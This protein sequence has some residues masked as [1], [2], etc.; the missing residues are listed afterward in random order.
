MELLT[1]NKIVSLE[2]DIPAAI[3]TDTFASIW[4][5]VKA[6]NES[7]SKKT[8]STSQTST[9][10][11]KSPFNS[12]LI[13]LTDPLATSPPSPPPSSLGIVKVK[14]GQPRKTDPKLMKA[15]A[16]HAKHQ[17]KISEKIAVL[18]WYTTHGSNQSSTA[19][20]FQSIYPHLNIKQP[21]VSSWVKAEARL[22]KQSLDH[23][24]AMKHDRDLQY[25][26]VEKL[27]TKWVGEAILANVLID[28]DVI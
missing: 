11:K 13:S 10:L 26:G 25:P 16:L 22:R 17:A 8:T 18:D 15:R 3:S 12:S 20:H 21:L 4:K 27:L 9:V 2:E 5:L 1:L 6:G 14:M 19:K 23:H 24:A 7:D 28:G